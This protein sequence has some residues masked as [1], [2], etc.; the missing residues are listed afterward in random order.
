MVAEALLA[1]ARFHQL[2]ARK[3]LDRAEIARAVH[4]LCT[5]RAHQHL[6][7]AEALLTQADAANR[8]GNQSA[9]IQ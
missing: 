7:K 1:L 3:Q 2:R 9:R 5:Q 6:V 4:R 8:Q